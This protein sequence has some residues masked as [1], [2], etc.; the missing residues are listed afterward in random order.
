MDDVPLDTIHVLYLGPDS[1]TTAAVAERL[2]DDGPG[3]PVEDRET[4]FEWGY[5]SHENG[6]GFGLATVEQIVDAHGGSIQ[7]TDGESGGARFEIR[8]IPVY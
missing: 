2:E 6:T 7:V 4:V 3:V 5:T 1:N 8:G